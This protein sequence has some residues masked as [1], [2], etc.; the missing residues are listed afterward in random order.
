MNI[1]ERRKYNKEYMER[2]ESCR[3]N[4]SQSISNIIHSQEY[5]ILKE[6]R[7]RKRKEERKRQKLL[8][9]IA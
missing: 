8:K 3:Y 7:I 9:N 1:K 5:M 4:K 2:I 6:E